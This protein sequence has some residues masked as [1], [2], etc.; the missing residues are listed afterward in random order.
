MLCVN[1]KK[2][3]TLASY[4]M[5]DEREGAAASRRQDDCFRRF[6]AVSDQAPVAADDTLRG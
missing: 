5:S 1:V 3:A 4:T 2:W 6:D